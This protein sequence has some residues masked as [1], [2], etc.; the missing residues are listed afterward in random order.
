MHPPAPLGRA[1]VVAPVFVK[2]DDLSVMELE[3]GAAVEAPPTLLGIHARCR[4]DEI[5][6]PFADVKLVL[7]IDA[8]GMRVG[9]IDADEFIDGEAL[10][11]V[12]PIDQ[13]VGVKK[14]R[15]ATGSSETSA[16]Q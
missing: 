4:D 6:V 14:A 11:R 8:P 9:D 2:A 12:V 15:M 5:L 3:S 7:D 10:V 16:V 13:R 1:P